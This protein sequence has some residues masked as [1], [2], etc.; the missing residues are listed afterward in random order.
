MITF[1][2]SPTTLP[3]VTDISCNSCARHIEKDNKGYFEDYIALNK[4]W[5]YHSPYDGERHTLD[6]CSDCYRAWVSEFKMPPQ[7][8]AL[9]HVWE[10]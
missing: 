3:E 4:R 8:E 2:K 7:V 9:Q 6:I 10:G 5:G 1:L